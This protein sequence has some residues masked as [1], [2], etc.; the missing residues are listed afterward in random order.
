MDLN[1]SLNVV[2]IINY[3]HINKPVLSIEFSEN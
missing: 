3:D 2:D 1:V